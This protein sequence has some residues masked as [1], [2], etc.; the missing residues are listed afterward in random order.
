MIVIELQYDAHNRSFTSL[1]NGAADLFEDGE[2]YL[3]RIAFNYLSNQRRARSIWPVACLTE[4]GI[5]ERKALND[6]IQMCPSSSSTMRTEGQLE[7]PVCLT[8]NESFGS[9]R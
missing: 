3:A 8:E 2:L 9:S 4:D 7:C 5:G 1:D 6:G